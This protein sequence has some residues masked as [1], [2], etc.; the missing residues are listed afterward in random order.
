MKK[1]ITV[2][3][4]LLLLLACTGCQGDGS[5]AAQVLLTSS[6][7]PAEELV[8]QDKLKAKENNK[9]VGYQL[10][11]PEE[12]EEIAIIT[13]ADGKS[14]KLRFFAD[15]APKT[16]YNFKKHALDGYYDGL[17]FHRIIQGFMIQ[18][19]DPDGNGTGGESVWGTAFADEFSKNLLNLNGAV[20]MANSG[21]NTNG[22]QFFINN[23]ENT[24]VNWD[25]FTQMYELFKQD[26]SY[27]AGITG[28][29]TPHTLDMEK[30]TEQVKDAYSANGGNPNLD[31]YY[32]SGSIGHT[33]FAQV[34]EG[35]DA[36]KEIAA[37]KTNDSVPAEPVVIEKIEIVKF[38]G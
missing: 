26:A 38:Q 25:Q 11:P 22:S 15:Q 9:E 21:Q 32:D 29:S 8:S 14:I 23:T 3:L 35:M 37:V 34:F 12:G 18:G 2:L 36:V 1:I 31:G 10:A 30:V 5:N 27:F 13:M 4:T 20:A 28:Q 17:T 19:G 7:A 24:E 16:V 6:G 33:V